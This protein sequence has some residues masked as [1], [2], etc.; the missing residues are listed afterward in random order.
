MS[1][2]FTKCSEGYLMVKIHDR[3]NHL[4]RLEA[5]TQFGTNLVDAQV[6]LFTVQ[7]SA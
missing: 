3:R 4:A 6:S 1:E 5:K 2:V 7:L